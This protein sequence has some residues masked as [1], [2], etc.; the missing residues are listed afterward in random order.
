AIAKAAHFGY[1]MD[2]E[3]LYARMQEM[4]R[5]S[6]LTDIENYYDAHHRFILCLISFAENPYQ[7]RIVKQIFFQMIHF[8]DGINMFKSVEIR[9]WTNK[10]SNQICELL[11]EEETELARKT[12]KSMFAELTIQAYR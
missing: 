9:E 11:A 7:V 5:L 12:I 10:K 1:E 8:S 6:Y 4:E 2:L 3:K